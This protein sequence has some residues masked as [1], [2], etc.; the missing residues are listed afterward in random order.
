MS[1]TP[2]NVPTEHRQSGLIIALRWLAVLPAALLAFFAIQLLVI[3][4]NAMMAEGYASWVLQLVNSAASSYAFIHAGT[5]TAPKYQF[6]VGVILAALMVIFMLGVVVLRAYNQTSDPFWWIA[7][8]CAISMV[9]TLCA[10]K[11][12]RD[13]RLELK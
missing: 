12:L 5:Y 2:D 1:L 7:L 13:I 6:I 9:A 11:Q 10:V 8:A 3:L 4:M